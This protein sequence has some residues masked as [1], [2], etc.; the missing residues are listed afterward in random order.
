[1]TNQTKNLL[2]SGNYQKKKKRESEREREKEKRL[3]TEWK[4]LF[5]NNIT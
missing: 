1:M 4:K 2:L 5:L 3:P